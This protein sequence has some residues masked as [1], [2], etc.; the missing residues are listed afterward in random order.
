MIENLLKEFK[1]SY[2]NNTAKQCLISDIIK[3]TEILKE[4]KDSLK[5]NPF[6]KFIQKDLLN[7]D[8]PFI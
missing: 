8:Y 3:K 7:S 4:L 6:Y 5:A 2:Q 1:S